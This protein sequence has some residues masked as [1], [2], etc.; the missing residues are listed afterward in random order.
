MTGYPDGQ[1]AMLADDATVR[2]IYQSESYAT[3]GRAPK[4]ETYPWQMKNGV[5]FTGSW[6][7]TALIAKKADGSFY[8]MEDLRG[9][10]RQ[11]I[12]RKISTADQTYIGVVQARPESSGAVEALGG[13]AGGQIFIFTMNPE[14]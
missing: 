11:D 4:P 13:D 9:A 5:T 3:M 6:P 2:V 7:V 14:K 10:A 12:R 8:S 1:A